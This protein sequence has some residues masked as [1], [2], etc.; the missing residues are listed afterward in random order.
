MPAVTEA[1]P[2]YSYGM[3]PKNQLRAASILAFVSLSLAGLS[4]ETS[5]PV[6]SAEE[7]LGPAIYAEATAKGRAARTGETPS[8]LPSHPAAERI[9]AALAAEKGSILVESAFVLPRAADPAKAR[10]ELAAIYGTMRSFGTMQGIEYYSASRKRMRTLYAQSYR[11]DSEQSRVRLPDPG[12]PPP[13]AIPATETLL[14]F[15]E[16]LSLGANVYRYSFA[17]YPDAVLVEATN[18]TKMRYGPITAVEPRGF[19]TRVLVIQADDAIVFYAAS[20]AAAPGL[21]KG[22]LSESLA[23][24]AEALFRW[25]SSRAGIFGKS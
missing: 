3:M 7:I 6:S 4:A 16:D 21:F 17:T 18:L 10:A 20:S 19:K 5:A 14:A 11:I 15:Q 13:D 1:R 22:R 9:R 24:R 23:N 8:I 25:F 2:G 12:F